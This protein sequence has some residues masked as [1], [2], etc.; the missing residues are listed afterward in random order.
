MKAA[1]VKWLEGRGP[2]VGADRL[3][4][5]ERGGSFVWEYP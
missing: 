1:A 2:T 5:Q 3:R 4:L